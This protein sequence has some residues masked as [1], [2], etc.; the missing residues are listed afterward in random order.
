M[1]IV[2]IGGVAG[3]ASAA[4]KARRTNEK[5]RITILERG[6]YVSF[7]NCGLPYHIGREIPEMSS[8]LVVK[9]E[10]FSG[11][12]GI[13][14]RLHTEVLALNPQEKTLELK[15]SEGNSTLSYDRLILAQGAAPLKPPLRGV[16]AEHVFSLR[17]IEDMVSIDSFLE[18]QAVKQAVVVGGGF[19]G[20]EM[21]EAL[22]HRGLDVV[23]VERMPHVMPLLDPGIGHEYQRRLSGRGLKVLSEESVV[24]VTSNSVLLE[25][26]KEIP[27]GIVL[28]AIGVRPELELARSAGLELGRNGG[29]MVDE[30]MRT[31]IQDIY[32]VGDMVEILHRVS[33]ERVR[34]PLAG[35]ANRQGR[36]AGQNAAGGTLA[37]YRGALGTSIVRCLGEVAAS[38]GLN[39]AQIQKL[40]LKYDHSET[41]DNHHAGYYPGAAPLLI[42][43]LWEASSGRLLG[44]QILGT[45]GVDKRIDVLA[46]A[47]IA[48]M[49]VEDLQ[50]LDLAYAPPFGSANDPVHMAAFTA[51]NLRSGQYQGIEYS[52]LESGDLLLDVRSAAELRNEGTLEG[53]MHIPLPELRSRLGEIPANQ[54]IVVYCRK[55]QRGY[56]AERILRQLGYDAH[57]LKGGFLQAL[58]MGATSVPGPSSCG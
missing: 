21:A 26:G 4:V 33:G 22:I 14:V 50:E 27:A 34:I 32:A 29:L 49:K 11:K 38:T 52:E 16:D 30:H 13:E 47:L 6:G 56:V 3:G 18:S 19:I 7:A 36:V 37:E 45:E 17:S 46:T 25:S 41:L 24:E 51:S 9:P 55:G 15:T 20:L 5:A 58:R 1:H 39:E 10:D 35:P 42:R 40:G 53:S 12:F 31:S 23:V 43:I 44:A 57:G 8:L 54:R 2:I 48:G 28:M